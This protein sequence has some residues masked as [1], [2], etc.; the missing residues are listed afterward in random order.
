MYVCLWF[1]MKQVLL[2]ETGASK[3]TIITDKKYDTHTKK[4][5]MTQT[6]IYDDTEYIQM[7]SMTT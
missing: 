5:R 6:Y 1:V 4:N 7:L 2:G 3:Q